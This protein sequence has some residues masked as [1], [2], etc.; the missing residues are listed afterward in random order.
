MRTHDRL[1]RR[2][3]WLVVILLA[4][5]IIIATVIGPLSNRY[6][7]P[8]LTTLS[9]VAIV[10]FVFCMVLLGKIQGQLK[11]EKNDQ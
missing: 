1:N 9:I 5:F 8:I 4:D 11:A 3:R 7:S 6:S 10:V 2:K